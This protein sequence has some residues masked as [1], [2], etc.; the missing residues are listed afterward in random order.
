MHRFVFPTAGRKQDNYRLSEVYS[1][2]LQ[3]CTV[4]TTVQL[5]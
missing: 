3:I 5:L 2:L 1:V 4:A